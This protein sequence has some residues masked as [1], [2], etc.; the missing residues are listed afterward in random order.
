MKFLNNI[1]TDY[2]VVGVSALIILACS[3][4]L[5]AD[6]TSRVEAGDVKKIGTI[7]Y[8]RKVAQRKYVSQVVW[9]DIEQNTPVYD[10]DSIRTAD[11]SEAVINLGDGTRIN[12]DENSLILLAS[13]GEGI[14]IDFSHGSISANRGGAGTGD[15]AKINIQSKDA[16]VSIEKGD[17]KL[18]RSGEKKL[19]VTVSDGK[20][21]I[22]TD[23]GEKTVGKDEKATITGDVTR[24]S[25]LTLKLSSPAPNSNFISAAAA[26][27]VDFR[28]EPLEKGA[29]ATLE[30]SRDGN[31]SG[32]T[33]SRPV[34]KNASV[35]NL[36]E[37]SYYWRITAFNR[38]ANAAEYS[39]AR[40]INIIRERPVRPVYPRN[41]E[42]ITYSVKPPIV[43]F[44]WEGNDLASE[45]IVEISRD[46]AFK[47][48]VRSVAT[49][50]TDAP[51]DRLDAGTY[52]WRVKSRNASVASYT[53]TS[54]VSSFRIDREAEIAPPV[55][56][57]PPDGRRVSASMVDKGRN[58]IFSWSSDGQIGSY[59]ITVARDREFKNIVLSALSKQN[60]YAIR[61]RLDAGGYFWRVAA[62]PEGREKGILSAP[63]SLTVVSA[64]RVTAGIP[65]VTGF[66]GKG[67][68]GTAAAVLFPWDAGGFKGSFRL[69]LSRDNAFLNVVSA[70]NTPE[71]SAVITGIN[72]GA[73][74]W[75]VTLYDD[76]RSQIAE[77]GPRPLYLSVEGALVAS[78]DKI[79]SALAASE[80]SQKEEVARKKELDDIARKENE[81]AKK[82][83]LELAHQQE[84]ERE[85]ARRA[86]QELAR[87]ERE[88]LEKKEREELEVKRQED[89]A[90]KQKD[91]LALKAERERALKER[92][93]VEKKKREED[94][95]RKKEDEKARIAKGEL[96]AK[97]KEELA[98]KRQ[99][100]QQ[101]KEQTELER[102]LQ[103]DMARKVKRDAELKKLQEL[104]LKK[105]EEKARKEKE[106]LAKKEKEEL[107]RKEKLDKQKEQAAEVKPVLTIATSEKGSAI[108]INSRLK[109]YDTLTISPRAG[110]TV[111]VVVRA[112]GFSD[113]RENIVLNG[114]EKKRIDVKLSQNITV[115]REKKPGRRLRWR[116]S[117][118]STVMSRPVYC[119]NMIV[120]T[121]KNGYLAGLS[122]NGGQLW[123][124][125]LGSAARSTPAADNTAA[126]VVTVNGVLFAVDLR[127]G[128]IKW[129]KPVEGPLLFGSEPIAADGR[130]YVAT[131]YG[132]LQA[133]SQDGAEVWR[134][135]L[136]EGIFSSIVGEGGVLYVGTDRSMIYA[137][138]AKD[139]SV[140]WTFGT[141][142]RIFTS[143]PRVYRGVLFVGCY[144]G[145]FYAINARSG[146]L[147]WKFKAKKAIL[148]SAA[149]YGDSVFFGSEDGTVYA[150][151]IAG[152]EKI[153]EFSTRGSIVTGPD[154]S[155]DSV[156]V[157]SGST[158]FSIDVS[159][160]DLNW[161]EG[162][163]SGI[164]TP[165]TV[166]GNAAYVGLNNG[167][168]VSLTSF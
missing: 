144:S 59:E 55:L 30:I 42:I 140:R 57:S 96:E 98:R 21:E 63:N 151:N 26:M 50:I 136:E 166:A 18:S 89:L 37:G 23:K 62:L 121:T 160:G 142:S 148:S 132:M 107:A 87:K 150:L 90:Q 141:D 83:Q 168:V 137:I 116:T 46:P 61:E 117:L 38:T 5:Y 78:A 159:S 111:T 9:E 56:I 43:H 11:L 124:T 157:P 164:N 165:V 125:A 49:Q 47:S 76:D 67:T 118:A 3:A 114:G 155:G 1:N 143:S 152:G 158:V 85:T 135:N 127:S 84:M 35:E 100:E 39:D 54:A 12:L 16:V 145:T 147:K 34:L 6:F 99:A 52:Y 32:K 134:R 58:F 146:W 45:Y 29:A 80:A 163:A 75:R 73:Y 95:A 86:E 33:V 131:S 126:Y 70:K 133:F 51:G 22:K 2:L 25:R 10:N 94:L 154:V 28:W 167:E 82:K 79:A 130:I 162:L 109:G 68:D 88:D 24:V 120:V 153:W 81:L 112:E 103:E 110:E 123:R 13:S 113:Y 48:M 128:R 71:T 14:N 108:Y 115:H 74:F 8:K 69:E 44:R 65:R 4:M 93:D 36:G 72:P 104:A 60:F 119:N 27:P 41:N 97:R 122:L 129:K 66:T 77:T 101:L 64:G 161:K 40:K 149:C 156:L 17:V 53:G 105:T 106:I 20:A 138:N 19:D 31:F 102:K 92:D 15:A 139:G 7:T 91:D